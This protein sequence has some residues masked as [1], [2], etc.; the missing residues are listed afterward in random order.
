MHI[1]VAD[2]GIA[3][4]RYEQAKRHKDDHEMDRQE[5]K[6]VNAFTMAI[7]QGL[8]PFIVECIADMVRTTLYGLDSRGRAIQKRVE[9]HETEWYGRACSLSTIVDI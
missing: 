7:E 8:H 4:W 5:T 3:Q 6:M 2:A 9:Q 1:Y